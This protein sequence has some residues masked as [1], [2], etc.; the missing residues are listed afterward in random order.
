M[1]SKWFM[2]GFA[3]MAAIMMVTLNFGCG[4]GEEA[5]GSAANSDAIVGSTG[6]YSNGLKAAVTE[7]TAGFVSI[8][9]SVVDFILEKYES[10]E[11]N[12]QLP[13]VKDA[14]NTYGLRTIQVT[15]ETIQP[16]PSGIVAASFDN[17]LTID[18]FEKLFKEL[19]AP[20]EALKKQDGAL[21]VDEYAFQL[22]SDGH[23]LYFGYKD[24][25]AAT[26]AAFN[27][28]E[29]KELPKDVVSAI[30]K[31]AE[32][33]V[34]V[35]CN[36]EIAE[37]YKA[38]PPQISGMVGNLPKVLVLSGN[39]DKA[40]QLIANYEK[41]D[42]AKKIAETL[43]GMLKPFMD[44]PSEIPAW[45][46][47]LLKTVEIA[48]NAETVTIS[49][50][51]NLRKT[52]DAMCDDATEKARNKAKSISCVTNLKQ[53]GLGL[54]IW[55]DENNDFLPANKDWEKTIADYVGDEKTF[56]CPACQK[57]YT[58]YGNGQSYGKLKHPSNTVT[59]VCS[60]DHEGTKNVLFADGH[61]ASIRAANVEAAVK[62]APKGELPVL[63]W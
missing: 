15:I 16:K 50:K 42:D 22:V 1:K 58:F 59:V 53:I 60:A 11:K 23:V 52:L 56:V 46:A 32:I 30:G 47:E 28:G 35:L 38:V 21:L 8:D 61:V 13:K 40:Q 12:P 51:G 49:C 39:L 25:V 36:A 27:K 2:R 33:C 44:N 18:A 55:G 9:R 10:F 48:D 17:P 43:R 34:A 57:H 20:E 29:G 62:A 4:K 54:R 45:A 5:S 7:K 63:K 37:L 31:D 14:I 3:V 41:A 19:G 24:T 6:K 26:V